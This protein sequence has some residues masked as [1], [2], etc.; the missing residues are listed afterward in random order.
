[1]ECSLWKNK[2]FVLKPFLFT[3]CDLTINVFQMSKLRSIWS[4]L[5]LIIASMYFLIFVISNQAALRYHLQERTSCVP[6]GPVLR[7]R[8]S[9]WLK[10]WG[11]VVPIGLELWDFLFLS[12]PNLRSLGITFRERQICISIGQECKKPVFQLA[13]GLRK[14]CSYWSRIVGFLVVVIS[15]LGVFRYHL[16][17]KTELCSYW[18]NVK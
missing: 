10:G 9:S 11:S 16:Q 7:S 6:I 4:K 3:A 14:R 13:S 12:Y 5:I 15:N 17:G 18:S 8:C 2:S 1:M